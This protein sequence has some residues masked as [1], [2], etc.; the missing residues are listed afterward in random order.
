MITKSRAFVTS[1]GA[2]HA[3]IDDAKTCELSLLVDGAIPT[4]DLRKLVAKSSEAIAIL[5]L[6]LPRQKRAAKP[7]KVVKKD[8]P[9]AVPSTK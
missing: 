6:G 7:A 9:L 8:K 4:Q 5:R 2:T 3:N 1:D